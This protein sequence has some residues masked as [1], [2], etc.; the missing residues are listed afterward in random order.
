MRKLA[1]FL[2]LVALAAVAHAQPPITGTP[3]PVQKT[4]EI[5]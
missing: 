4:A 3:E 5:A 1:P 2:L